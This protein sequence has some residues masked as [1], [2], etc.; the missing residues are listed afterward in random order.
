VTLRTDSGRLSGTQGFEPNDLGN[1]ATAVNVRLSGTVTSLAP[2]LIPLQ[3]R[4]MWSSG[5]VFIP[6]LL[7]ASLADI[8]CRVLPP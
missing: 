4:S 2:V 1:I 3:K 6:D 5:K 7:V 8:S